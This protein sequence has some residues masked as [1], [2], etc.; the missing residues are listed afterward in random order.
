MGRFQ[1]LDDLKPKVVHDDS[2]K[3]H[4]KFDDNDT[5]TPPAK[6]VKRKSTSD[7][8]AVKKQK[9]DTP[10]NNKQ[11]AP[12]KNGFKK[13]AAKQATDKKTGGKQLKKAAV[14]K[15]TKPKP[16]SPRAAEIAEK[17]MSCCIA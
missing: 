17:S 10:P 6:G 5:K 2:R 3:V 8:T 4:V 11:S 13:D 7:S 14:K 9:K 15:D 1:P 16:I 12:K